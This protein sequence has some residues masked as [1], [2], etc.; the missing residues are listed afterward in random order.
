MSIQRRSELVVLA[1]IAVVVVVRL[2]ESDKRYTFGHPHA[3]DIAIWSLLLILGITH[4]LL[5][6]VSWLQRA[7]WTPS[8][9]AMFRFLS[10]KAVFWVNTAAQY[11]W[12]GRGISLDTAV[13]FVAMTAT[14]I[15]M[16]YKMFRRFI[17]G[18]EDAE[19]YPEE[20]AA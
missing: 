3:V 6:A 7:R 15:D 18:A 8:E 9:A 10:V 2:T 12:A 13:L 17:L 16:D 19:L 14:T 20:Q 1:M 4:V 11:G 5:G